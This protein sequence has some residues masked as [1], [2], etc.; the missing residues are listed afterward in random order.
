MASFKSVQF[1]EQ[2]AADTNSPLSE[3]TCVGFNQYFDNT[4]L[5]SNQAEN[6]NGLIR[7][8]QTWNTWLVGW[9]VTGAPTFVIW[10]HSLIQSRDLAP[11]IN[12]VLVLVSSAKM[13]TFHGIANKVN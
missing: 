6:P 3:Y 13:K 10:H 8:D 5:Q 9:L 2:H 1:K 4:S 11:L 7:P 12:I